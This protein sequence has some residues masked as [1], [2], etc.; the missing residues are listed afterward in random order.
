MVYLYGVLVHRKYPDWG[1]G[2]NEYKQ[3]P[4]SKIQTYT[5]KTEFEA[6]TSDIT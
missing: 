5:S 6:M 4:W 3:R 2:N 1:R